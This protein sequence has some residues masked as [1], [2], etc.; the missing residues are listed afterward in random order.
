[1][2]KVLIVYAHPNLE[3]FNGAVLQQVRQGL[4]EAGHEVEIV[5]LYRENFDPVL[6]F[7]SEKKKRDI[8][9]DPETEKYRQLVKKAEHLV[10][11][12]P[13]W[14]SGIAA[15]IKAMSFWCPTASASLFPIAQ[16]RDALR[17]F[18]LSQYLQ[19]PY[20]VSA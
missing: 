4:E 5:D 15:S 3:S 9:C 20:S 6:R 16:K 19:A 7:N 2:M 8:C 1:M 12:Y 18:S 10:F 11:I 17:S 14:W 13:I